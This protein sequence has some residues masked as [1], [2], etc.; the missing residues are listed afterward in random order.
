[1]LVEPDSLEPDTR[2]TVR[3]EV[4]EDA[5]LEPRD[6]IT[7]TTS[8]V[9]DDTAP[10]VEPYERD[11]QV[12]HRPADPNSTC[13]WQHEDSWLLRIPLPRASDD[14]V[15]AGYRLFEVDGLGDYRLHSAVLEGEREELTVE[16]WARG[17]ALF[18]FEVFDLA[19]NVTATEQF[20][21]PLRDRFGCST[22]DDVGD[23]LPRAALLLGPLA[24]LLRRRRRR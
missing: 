20:V 2:Y 14:V 16:R 10:E 12:E 22:T 24:L 19:G 11:V 18:V 3:F 8:T 21:V 7:F 4:T 13:Q 15:V 5:G 17:E 9:T 6:D 23:D 1:V